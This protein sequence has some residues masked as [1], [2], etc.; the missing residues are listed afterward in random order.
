MTDSITW[1]AL[2]SSEKRK[3]YF[4]TILE[5]L[6]NLRRKNVVIY[7][8]KDNIFQALQLTP[9]A[10]ARVI[11]LG[12]DPYH[13]E[14][15]AHGLSFSV[16]QPVPPPPSLQNIFKELKRDLDIDAPGHGCLSGW[17]KQGVLLLNASLTVEAAKPQSHANL[18]WHQFTDHIVDCL[19]DHP[20]PLVFML[21]GASAQKKAQRVDPS[22]HLLLKAPHPSPLSC[23]RGYIGCSHFSKA[24][25]FLVKNGAKPIMWERFT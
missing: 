12:Q 16:Q 18:G 10:D 7:P 9:Y 23:H 1:G 3:P 24:N 25:D 19:N 20:H 17:A 14:N 5:E 2:L 22:R 11:I 6:N 15:Q 21:W 4:Q 13:G 8:P